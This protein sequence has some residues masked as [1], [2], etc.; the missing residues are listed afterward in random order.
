MVHRD[1]FTQ[2]LRRA[3]EAASAGRDPDPNGDVARRALQDAERALM[4]AIAHTPTEYDNHVALAS[5][6]N[7]AGNAWKDETHF[8]KAIDAAR[9]A[10]EVS[11]FGAAARYELAWAYAQTGRRS[12][13]LSELEY[14]HALDPAFV[15][16]ALGLAHLYIGDLRYVDALSVLNMTLARHRGHEGLVEALLRADAGRRTHASQQRRR[17][18]RRA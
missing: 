10:I 5:V 13:A 15:D 18:S 14:T 1:A 17:R 2:A 4:G 12:L 8:L 3:G 6:R 16:C 11:P 7:L 9:R